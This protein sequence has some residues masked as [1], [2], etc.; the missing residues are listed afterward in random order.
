MLSGN[1]GAL[2]REVVPV[3]QMRRTLAPVLMEL[4]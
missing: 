2:H 1:G 4:G 3:L